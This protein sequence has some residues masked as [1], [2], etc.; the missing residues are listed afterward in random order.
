MSD[1]ETELSLLIPGT[2]RVRRFTVSIPA[3]PVSDAIPTTVLDD[4]ITSIRSDRFL[5]PQMILLGKSAWSD[6][7][8]NFSSEFDV[9]IRT[10]RKLALL[11]SAGTAQ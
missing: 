6:L 1:Y 2:G 11:T 3:A 5:T 9:F 8:G 4:L 7:M 10:M